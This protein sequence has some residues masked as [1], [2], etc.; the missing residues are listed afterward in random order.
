MSAGEQMVG[1]RV[2]SPSDT[3]E[4]FLEK[5]E[6]EICIESSSSVENWFLVPYKFVHNWRESFCLTRPEVN[7]SFTFS[8]IEAVAITDIRKTLMY[9]GHTAAA[10][11]YIVGGLLNIFCLKGNNH[12]E[13]SAT[14]VTRF[15]AKFQEACQ[16]VGLRTTQAWLRYK[17][18]ILAKDWPLLLRWSYFSLN[19]FE[20]YHV[21]L[22][23]YFQ[24]IA[25]L[26]KT[27]IWS[28]SNN[29]M[30]PL[31]DLESQILVG[32]V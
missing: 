19:L 18:Y 13:P 22:A 28:L 12:P 17:F 14:K 3:F 23:K 5:L 25:L 29:S 32:L 6:R 8:E 11:A 24:G 20:K 27:S 9:E 4:M 31:I 1:H 15:S 16:R 21:C 7:N 30:V 26:G 2:E 10:G